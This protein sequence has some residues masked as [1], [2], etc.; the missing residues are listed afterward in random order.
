MHMWT[1]RSVCRDLKRGSC[2]KKW[3]IYKYFYLS[4]DVS[5]STLMRHILIG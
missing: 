5:N 4:Y 1:N 3:Y 2:G